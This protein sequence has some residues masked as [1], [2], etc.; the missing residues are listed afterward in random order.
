M[1]AFDDTQYYFEV[2]S[3]QGRLASV[4]AVRQHFELIP[5]DPQNPLTQKVITEIQIKN[6]NF[7]V[8]NDQADS[9]CHHQA[10]SSKVIFCSYAALLTVFHNGG[11]F[12]ANFTVQ[13]TLAADYANICYQNKPNYL[14]AEEG[15]GC[16]LMWSPSCASGKNL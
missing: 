1:V 4:Q 9:G 6:A 3:L 11:R 10:S 16:S 5:D 2:D 8:M 13:M 15:H 7:V 14:E 12:G